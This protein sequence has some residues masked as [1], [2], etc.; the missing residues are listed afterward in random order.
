ML[1]SGKNI[2]FFTPGLG[3]NN[4]VTEYFASFL[5]CHLT[6]SPLPPVKWL[7]LGKVV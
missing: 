7:L 5:T 1:I 2:F 3:D 6:P 4:S